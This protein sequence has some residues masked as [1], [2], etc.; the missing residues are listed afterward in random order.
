MRMRFIARYVYTFEEF[1]IETEAPLYNRKTAI[2][3][4]AGNKKNNIQMYKIG[5]V[6]KKQKHNIKYRQL[7]L[8]R[9]DMCKYV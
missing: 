9:H 8:Y 7:S 3:Q 2:G 4:E 6:Q 1:V 5:N